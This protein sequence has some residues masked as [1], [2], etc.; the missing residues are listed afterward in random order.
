MQV[1]PAGVAGCPCPPAC[2][3]RVGACTAQVVSRSMES[4][5]GNLRGQRS[6][7]VGRSGREAVERRRFQHRHALVALVPTRPAQPRPQPTRS[8]RCKTRRRPPS[9]CTRD[10]HTPAQQVARY[11]LATLVVA[12][13]ATGGGPLRF[14]AVE[15][16]KNASG[17]ETARSGV[18]IQGWTHPLLGAARELGPSLS[19]LRRLACKL[20]TTT[21]GRC[22]LAIA[23][24]CTHDPHE[25]H[26]KPWSTHRYARHR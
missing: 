15:T 18:P 8:P 21:D 9:P 17:E 22:P 24:I 3:R 2:S 26:S 14:K 4:A 12:A 11:C 13:G 23:I 10:S 6:S 7:G 5:L 16:A 1:N 25:L 20:H 19:R